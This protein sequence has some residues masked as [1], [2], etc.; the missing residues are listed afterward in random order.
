[1]T[2]GGFG[3][4]EFAEVGDVIAAALQPDVDTAALRGRVADLA[5]RFPLYPG[6]EEW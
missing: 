1:M 5:E 3:D 2:I 4:A 6:L